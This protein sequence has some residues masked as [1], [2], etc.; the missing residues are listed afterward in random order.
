MQCDTLWTHATS[1]GLPNVLIEVRQD[2]I[3][4]AAGVAK[5]TPVIAAALRT[6]LA[7]LT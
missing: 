1:R 3:A 5:L 6:A 7:G 2:L 4:D